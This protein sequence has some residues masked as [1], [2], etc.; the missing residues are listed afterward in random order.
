M[1]ITQSEYAKRQG[2]H[3]TTIYRAIADGRLHAVQE[4]KRLYIDENEPFA[5]LQKP[6][7]ERHGCAKTRLYNI[8]A[9]MKSRCLNEK[10]AR[11]HD[12]GGRGI[13]VC[14][15]W[16]N[17]F[18]SFRSWAMSHGYDDK[19]QIDRIDNDGGYCPENCRWV[20]PYENVHN[21]RPRQY[22]IRGR[23]SDGNFPEAVI[24]AP[25]FTMTIYRVGSDKRICRISDDSEIVT[26]CE[27]HP[28][29][30]GVY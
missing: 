12:Y 27:F 2:V 17:S 9:K 20:T 29:L 23:F 24:M 22:K 8:W 10:D 1:L 21:Q 25:D 4:G 3:R 18:V 30:R 14:D 16:I 13:T 15:E 26:W 6:T 7:M 5:H 11:Y 28:G 19:L